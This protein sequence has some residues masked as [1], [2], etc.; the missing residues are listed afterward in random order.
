MMHYLTLITLESTAMSKVVRIIDI[1]GG[2]RQGRQS[3]RGC[4]WGVLVRFLAHD[5]VVE[6]GNGDGVLGEAR[7]CSNRQ[8]EEVTDELGF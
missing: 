5:W 3:R 7:E 6:D 2:Q 8:R 1:D 4:S